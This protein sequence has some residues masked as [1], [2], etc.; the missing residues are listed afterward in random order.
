MFS[1]VFAAETLP[2]MLIRG[3]QMHFYI[4]AII[5]KLLAVGLITASEQ[6]VN[7]HIG[8]TPH[9]FVHL[10]VSTQLRGFARQSTK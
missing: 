1:C 8:Y 7:I 6:E 10:P 5:S 4:L 3:S 2:N 9:R